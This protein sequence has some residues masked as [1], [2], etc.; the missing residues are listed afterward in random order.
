M[1]GYGPLT[2]AAGGRQLQSPY[3]TGSVEFSLTSSVNLDARGGSNGRAAVVTHETMHALG[4]GRVS[5]PTSVM[6]PS[7]DPGSYVLNDGDRDG[8][9]TM[10]KNNPCP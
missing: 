10:Y 9:H 3:A 8:L 6:H 7:P 1:Y 5:D 4:F 2:A